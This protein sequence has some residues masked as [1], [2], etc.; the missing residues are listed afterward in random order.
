M[1]DGERSEVVFTGKREI[2]AIDMRG[3]LVLLG[4]RA[5]P[6]QL[7][8][9]VLVDIDDR[10]HPKVYN[11]QKTQINFVSISVDGEFFCSVGSSSPDTYH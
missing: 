2:S 4:E 9:A 11:Y 3:N 6:G 8:S 1:F 7:I 5:S 10:S